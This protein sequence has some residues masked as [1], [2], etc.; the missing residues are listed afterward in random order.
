MATNNISKDDIRK[1][2]LDKRK[3]FPKEMVEVSSD[4]ISELLI[5]YIGAHKPDL[6][7]LYSAYGREV[8][9]TK[10]INWCLQNNMKIALPRVSGDDMDFYCIESMNDLKPGAY[11]IL[12]PVAPEPINLANYSQVI[13][14]VPG[15]G[16]DRSFHR[17]GHGRGYY[18]RYF[19]HF[20]EV[21]LYGVCHD[22]QL[23]DSI[24]TDEHDIPMNMIFTDK[25]IIGN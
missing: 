6:L 11:G 5:D 22:F 20:P 24:P 7:L 1:I 19:E 4:R 3:H 10:V 16:F 15:V 2:L 18:D 8:S 21:M 25:E 13:C 23:I 14:I 17:M 9:L 12:E